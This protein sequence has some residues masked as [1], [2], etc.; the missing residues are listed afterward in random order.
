MGKSDCRCREARLMDRTT[1]GVVLGCLLGVL[2][3]APGQALDSRTTYA[4]QAATFE[5]Y[6]PGLVNG[7]KGL[8]GTAFAI[9][10]NRFVTTAHLLD[11][12]VGSRFG[13]PVLVDSHR[14]EY[15]IAQVLQYSEA[16]DYVIFSLK[17]PPRVTPLQ[18]ES[19]GSASG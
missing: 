2:C 4:V 14:V 1:L 17:H 5:F 18:V 7:A 13:H 9:G 19:G 3:S 8:V 10:P 11:T 16:R 15:P 12:A 6:A